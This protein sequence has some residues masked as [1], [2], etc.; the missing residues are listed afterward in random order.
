[1]NAILE[2][3]WILLIV[4]VSLLPIWIAAHRDVL[5]GRRRL[6]G[7][8]AIACLFTRVFGYVGLAWEIL[9]VLNA[10]WTLLVF[11][12]ATAATA[13]AGDSALDGRGRQP[14]F[15]ARPPTNPGTSTAAA[16]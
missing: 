14:E 13:R 7:M 15:V 8:F 2:F 12:A 10:G 1:M 9:L 16:T 11:W 3:G 5:P 6:I 4:G